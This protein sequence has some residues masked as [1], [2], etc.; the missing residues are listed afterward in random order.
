MTQQQINI[1]VDNGDDFYAHEASINFNAMQF[2]FDF[3]CVTP[4]TDM[5]SKDTQIISVKHNSV[6]VD[7]NMAKQLMGVLQKSISQYEEQ[8]GEIKQSEAVK[9][10]IKISQE[11]IDK[12]EVNTTPSYMG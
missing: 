7:V 3:K 2:I 1:V 10:M 8:F 9:K 6:M 5:R 4:R 11:A 12:G